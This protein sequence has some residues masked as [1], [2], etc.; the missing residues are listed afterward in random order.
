MF[1]V[2]LLVALWY[3]HNYSFSFFCS[4]K[5][6]TNQKNQIN[7]TEKCYLNASIKLQQSFTEY[8]MIYMLDRNQ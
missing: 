7:E 5:E 2:L 4:G 1:W 8:F 3:A 6:M